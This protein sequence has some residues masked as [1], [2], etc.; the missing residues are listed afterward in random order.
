MKVLRYLL[1]LS[2]LAWL[3]WQWP[4]LWEIALAGAIGGV[5][6]VF[7]RISPEKG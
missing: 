5:Y 1:L 7:F 6:W 4:M 3:V 2:A